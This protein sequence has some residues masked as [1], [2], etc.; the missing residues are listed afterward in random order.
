MGLVIMYLT[1]GIKSKRMEPDFLLKMPFM[2]KSTLGH[3]FR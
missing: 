1:Y 3:T 2:Q